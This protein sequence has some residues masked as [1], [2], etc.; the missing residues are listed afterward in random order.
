MS[1]H[2]A[3]HLKLIWYVY[4]NNIMYKLKFMKIFFYKHKALYVIFSSEL[5]YNYHYYIIV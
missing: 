4:F 3:V 5:N 2:Y 1:T